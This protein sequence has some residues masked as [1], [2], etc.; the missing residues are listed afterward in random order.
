MN[1]IIMHTHFQV[2][3]SLYRTSTLTIKTRVDDHLEP[4]SVVIFVRSK[5]QGVSCHEVRERAY[6]PSLKHSSVSGLLAE[7]MLGQTLR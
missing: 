7:H 6:F 4:S 2:A 5:K 1:A 3:V